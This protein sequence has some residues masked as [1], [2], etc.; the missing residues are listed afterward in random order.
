MIQGALLAYLLI[1]LSGIDR[2]VMEKWLYVIVA[3]T[4]I[5]GLLGTAHHY[6]FVGVPSYWLPIGGFFSALEPLVFVAMSAYPYQAIRRAGFAHEH[7]RGSLDDRQRA[8][9]GAR[10]GDCSASRIPGRRSTSGRTGRSSR[11]CTGIRRS[12]ARA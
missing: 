8:V 9:F 1:R 12:S 5:S 4:F 3:L 10:C 2:E 7:A 6:Y 11:R